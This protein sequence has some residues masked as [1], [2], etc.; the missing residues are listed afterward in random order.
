MRRWLWIAPMLVAA[1]WSQTKPDALNVVPVT[2]PGGFVIPSGTELNVRVDETLDTNRNERGDQFTATLTDPVVVNGQAVLPAGTHVTGH[3][4]E[5]RPAGILKGRAKLM[6]GLDAFQFSG[7][8]YPIELTAATYQSD[9][10][11]GK[12]KEPDPNASAV[13]GNREQV[14]IPAETV[15]HFTLGAPVRV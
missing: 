11:H 4:L 8:S 6:L 12:L 14:V 3:V 10:K 13:A 15:V 2:P 5:N 9:H 7:H 1:G